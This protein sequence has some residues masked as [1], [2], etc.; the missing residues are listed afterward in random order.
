MHE[1]SRRGLSNRRSTVSKVLRNK[2][3]YLRQDSDDDSKQP[4]RVKKQ[5]PDIDKA[6]SNWVKGRQSKNQ[7]VTD[8]LIKEQLRLFAT[9]V[10]GSDVQSKASS[11]SWL[12]KFK[13]R[14]GLSTSSSPSLSRKNSYAEES[15]EAGS[16]AVASGAGTPNTSPTSPQQN[17]RD[18][19]PM[20]LDASEPKR[21]KSESPPALFS[22]TMAGPSHKPFASISSAFTD[23]GASMAFTSPTMSPASPPFFE[24]P[25]YHHHGQR[26]QSASVAIAPAVAAAA[27]ANAANSAAYRQRSQTFP[28]SAAPAAADAPAGTAYDAAPT[29]YAVAEHMPAVLQ[30]NS[31][32][33]DISPADLLPELFGHCHSPTRA[34]H[35]SPGA[36]NPP[37]PRGTGSPP[38]GGP[39]TPSSDLIYGTGGS[40]NGSATNLAAMAAAGVQDAGGA[41]GAHSPSLDETRRALEV[42]WNFF[43]HQPLEPHEFAVMGKLMEKLKLHG[44]VTQQQYRHHQGAGPVE[45]NPADLVRIADALMLARGGE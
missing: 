25:A 16:A 23:G 41:G 28:M 31:S 36:T 34:H 3:K 8:A 35:H 9:T 21:M 11:A 37:S 39:L 22:E 43:Q 15:T 10:G 18:A 26:Q 42:V 29:P 13:A 20:D 44:S 24:A 4:P 38:S 1:A 33:A 40:A 14:N 6:L 12:E 17:K 30:Y 45:L 19:S 7:P 32:P 27:A 2:E 5:L